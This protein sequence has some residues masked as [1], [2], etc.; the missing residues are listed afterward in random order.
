MDAWTIRMIIPDSV[1]KYTKD[2]QP[3]LTSTSGSRYREGGKYNGS[4]DDRAQDI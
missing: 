4:Y 2:Y 3:R 1:W